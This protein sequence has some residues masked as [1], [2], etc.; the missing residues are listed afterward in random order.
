MCFLNGCVQNAALLAPAY[1][2]ANTG[3]LYQA[4]ISYGANLGIK[5]VT[6]KTPVENIKNFTNS[7][8]KITRNN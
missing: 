1:T 5:K 4:G 3:S 2:L 7:K 8:K 6:G